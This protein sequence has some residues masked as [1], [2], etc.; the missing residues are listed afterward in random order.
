MRQLGAPLGQPELALEVPPEAQGDQQV[1]QHLERRELVFVDDFIVAEHF[2]GAFARPGE[3]LDGPMDEDPLERLGFGEADRAMILRVLQGQECCAQHG[4][5]REIGM[6]IREL[7]KFD[8][9]PFMARAERRCQAHR[10]GCSAGGAQDHG[11]FCSTPAN[12]ISYCWAR[13]IVDDYD[14]RAG[15]DS[16]NVDMALTWNATHKTRLFRSGS[17]YLISCNFLVAGTGFEPVTFRL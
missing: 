14:C 2:F 5:M 10:E 12:V 15:V 1:V 16:Q 4:R 11:Q 3:V 13:V 6:V 9:V 8:H 7:A 17:K